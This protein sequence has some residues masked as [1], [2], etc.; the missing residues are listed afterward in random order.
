MTLAHR[1][2]LFLAPIVLLIGAW[3]A[4]VNWLGYQQEVQF[5][6]Q[7]AMQTDIQDLQVLARDPI[8]ERFLQNRTDGQ[9]EQAQHNLKEM[10]H[11]F[12]TQL[13]NAR[14]YDR[15]ADHMILFSPSWE[16]MVLESDNAQLNDQEKITHSDIH[17]E[18]FFFQYNDFSTPYSWLDNDHH[19]TVVAIGR[20]LNQDGLLT[21][22]E[23]RLFLH[24]E[25]LLPIA[26]F[27]D[28][29]FN[30]LIH[31]L[32]MALGQIVLLILALL[33]AGRFIPRPFQEFTGRIASLARG[34]LD[35]PFPK[36]WRIKELDLL[37]QAL[38]RMEEELRRRESHLI[39][40]HDQAEESRVML[41]QVL[42]TI[43][44]QVFWKDADFRY[45]GCNTRYAALAGIRDPTDIVNLC[46]RDMNWSAYA[47]SFHS[48]DRHVMA[49]GASHL[50]YL[51]EIHLSDGSQ[52]WLEVSKVPLIDTDGNIIGV[53]GVSHDVTE[54]QRLEE[55]LKFS[56]FSI[57]NAKDAIYWLDSRARF[58][59]VNQEA[60]VSLGQSR[61][62][63]LSMT[64][65]DISPE[66]PASEWPTLWDTIT[67]QRTLVFIT[68]HQRKDRSR[69]PV[70]IS[71]NLLEYH[72]T[73][74]AMAS[75]RNI[76]ERKLAEQALQEYA[77]K[78]EEMVQA[79]TKQLIHAERLA[80]L[81]TF[82]AGMAHE[83]NN[84][85]AF[86]ASNVQFLQQYWNL[87]HPVLLKHAGEDPSGRLS[88][89]HGEIQ[90]TLD[91]MLDGSARISKIVDSLKTYSKGGMETDRVECRLE[92]PVRDAHNLLQHRFRQDKTNLSVQIPKSLLIYCDRQQLAQVFVNLFNN[93]LDALEEMREQQHKQI[94]VEGKRIERHI[95]I[96]VK[97]NGP[98]IPEEVIGKIFDP[99]YTSKGKTRGTGLGLSIV[100]GIV[101][102]HR[103][104]VT[105]FSPPE[106]GRETEVVIILP[107]LE[108]YQEL[109]AKKK[110]N[111]PINP[112]IS[113]SQCR[114][115]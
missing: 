94:T 98:G 54:R 113:A 64:L 38:N 14:K 93:A 12:R 45:L 83:I 105:I 41:R 82:S 49:T 68:T 78:L 24:S 69:F 114:G 99:F 31:N 106:P 76:T 109:L 3:N 36:S 70:E 71:I 50:N 91:G 8:F 95:W 15:K 17:A 104:Q 87:A 88:R 111:R 34:N 92:D 110:P 115:P 51:E 26:E 103:G 16:V 60:C 9:L 73:S 4:V 107:T 48:V 33:W 23:V 10:R 37:S 72:G 63:L 112:V 97:D 40:A 35:Q 18:P 80:T 67:R 56:R 42:D 74:F 65:N 90:K 43:P 77:E 75:T 11:L 81:G 62:E 85:N 101:K 89:F 19:K 44:V 66:M 46:D 6:A 84:P 2:F 22:D 7:K 13:E 39:Q 58:I 108:L 59:N 86:I 21:R 52:R 32:W 1:F 47:D 57:M 30:R 79:R 29:A 96:W 5:I 61:E 102:D 27:R 28:E 53:L 100:E 55:E 20:D 25:F